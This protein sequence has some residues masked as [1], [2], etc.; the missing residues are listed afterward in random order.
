MA[1]PE[2]A[3]ACATKLVQ[4][5][6]RLK[7]AGETRGRG[8]VCSVGGSKL[9]DL[10]LKSGRKAD[11]L[12]LLTAEIERANLIT[13]S[14]CV[15]TECNILVHVAPAHYF[16]VARMLQGCNVLTLEIS[17]ATRI[18]VSHLL[19]VSCASCCSNLMMIRIPAGYLLFI[20]R[21]TAGCRTGQ[22]QP[23]RSSTFPA[24]SPQR[25]TQTGSNLVCTLLW[26]SCLLCSTDSL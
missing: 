3:G 22:F 8:C 10:G 7:H 4:Q 11:V 2:I 21:W 6:T 23:A 14:K 5:L 16:A 20:A 9:V 18:K 12:D 13:H 15:L 24:S 17:D 19:H 26:Y 1:T 25:L